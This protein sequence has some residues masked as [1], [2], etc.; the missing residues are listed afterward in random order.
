MANFMKEKDEQEYLKA[1]AQL[2]AVYNKNNS[3]F[4]FLGL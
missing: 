3:Y 2:P 4:N 1:T